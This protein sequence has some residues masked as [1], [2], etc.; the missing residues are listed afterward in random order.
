MLNFWWHELK[1]D[2]YYCSCRDFEKVWRIDVRQLES[3]IWRACCNENVNQLGQNIDCIG[4]MN[5]EDV[6]KVVELM[7]DRNRDDLYQ[8]MSHG[9]VVASNYIAPGKIISK[10][11]TEHE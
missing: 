7:I 10:G 9:N 8:A 5:A 2:N 1:K 6:M 11:E 4:R 3:K